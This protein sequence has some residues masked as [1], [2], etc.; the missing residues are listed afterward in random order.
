MFL[1]I[2]VVAWFDDECRHA[3]RQLCSTEGA[4]R[5]AG[6]ISDLNS[7]V[8]QAWRLQRRQYFSPLCHKR[9]D[10]WKAR[11]PADQQHPLRLWQSLD[12]LMGR[13]R[14]PPSV[15]NMSVHHKFFDDK[16]AGVRAA[17]AGAAEP[18]FTSC[19]SRLRTTSVHTSHDN[20]CN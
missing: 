15:M 1:V 19:T 4:A 2:V 20:G 16:I 12:Q 3:K 18:T 10:F 9:T 14:A 8:V 6:P 11:A 13:G 7:L 5:R 17:T